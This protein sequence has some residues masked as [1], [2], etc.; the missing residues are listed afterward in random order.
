MI[1][2]SSFWVAL[3][4]SLFIPSC[5]GLA[6]EGVA[7]AA[8]AYGYNIDPDSPSYLKRGDIIF[9]I[10]RNKD[11][12]I[13]SS[14]SVEVD[15]QYSDSDHSADKNIASDFNVEGCFGAFSAA[16]S[17]EV[18]KS[19]SSSIKTVRMDATV[20]ATKY[21]VS[22]KGGLRTFPHEHVTKNF[23]RAIEFLTNEEIETSIGIFF[24]TKLFLGG[25]IK[26][27]YTMQATSEDTEKSVTSEL[28]A[29]YGAKLMGVSG[30]AAMGLT[31]R[32]SN[33][34]SMMNIQWAAQGGKTEIWL[35]KDFSKEGESV[36]ATAAEWAATID[37]TNLYPSDFELRPMYD[38]IKAIPDSKK[39]FSYYKKGVEF[40]RYLK[41]KWG[42]DA[43]AFHPSRFLKTEKKMCCIKERKAIKEI[44][45]TNKYD[46][47][48]E[49]VM[50]K[51]KG[52]F[53]KTRNYIRY[54]YWKEA[55]RACEP[56]MEELLQKVTSDSKMSI[57]A[58]IEIIENEI[59]TTKVNVNSKKKGKYWNRI[60][61]K[62]LK[63]LVKVEDYAQRALK[64]HKKL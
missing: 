45:K 56:K 63:C 32:K 60:Q 57:R 42:K 55:A 7:M 23:K 25:A 19:T 31:T 41:K 22:A 46:C 61:E 2:V 24:A 18:S 30:S 16:A 9:D 1:A 15:H 21:E 5:E 62:T 39:G 53:W 54:G 43:S 14:A 64:E 12:S 47:T 20:K 8:I 34:D 44:L 27:S 28:K 48:G 6:N 40:E 13:S 51:E 26:K 33:K 58:F 35:G 49:L 17:M 3:C 37:E 52:R 50:A 59:A 11:L 10:D 4:V 38:L 29:S 36:S